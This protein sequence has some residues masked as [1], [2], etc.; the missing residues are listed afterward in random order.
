MIDIPA[1]RK[2]VDAGGVRVVV[3]GNGEIVDRDELSDF[4]PAVLIASPVTDAVKVVDAGLVQGSLD[5]DALWAIQGF[6]LSREVLLALDD[7]LIHPGELIS[8]V[9][10]AGFE[11][12]V[13]SS[14]S[15]SL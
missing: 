15:S 4:G 3:D 12:Q 7:D 14:S 8:A 5:R 11:W 2:L 10:R 6:V 1:L 13:I 9:T